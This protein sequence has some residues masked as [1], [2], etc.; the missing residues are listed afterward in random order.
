MKTVTFLA[1]FLTS[2]IL[3]GDD[4]K[5]VDPNPSFQKLIAGATRV[6]VRDGGDIC[7][8]TPA[9]TIKQAVLFE[10]KD[11][12]EIRKLAEN[13]KFQPG[14]AR[15]P[16][17]CCGH[18]GIDWYVGDQRVAITAVKHGAGIMRE[19]VVA[20]FTTASK[21]WVKKWLMEHGYKDELDTQKGVPPADGKPP[22]ASQ[23]PT[24]ATSNKRQ[25]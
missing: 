3:I 22:G 4:A 12:D 7:C 17:A 24:K 19:G 5:R 23:P 20:M 14:S 9:E 11:P 2:G 8:A 16:C 18:P 21:A 6:V 15:N 10:I 25:S 13:I 1:L